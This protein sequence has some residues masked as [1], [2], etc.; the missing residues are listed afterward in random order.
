MAKS[1][2]TKLIDFS[3]NT[4][5]DTDFGLSYLFSEQSSINSTFECKVI[6]K[7]YLFLTKKKKRVLFYLHVNFR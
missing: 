4:D 2:T 6:V 3:E 5:T 7:F 1:N